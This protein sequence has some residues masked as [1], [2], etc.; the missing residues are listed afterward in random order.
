MNG[1]D[2]ADQLRSY[3]NTQRTT[4]KT[5]KPLWHFLFDVV[6]TNSYLLATH[7]PPGEPKRFPKGH[8]KFLRDLAE[9]LFKH[10]ER[11]VKP[12]NSWATIETNRKV[13]ET[14]PLRDLVQ[15]DPDQSQHI[16]VV[17]S[18]PKACV[19]CAA[20]NRRPAT[21]TQRKPLEEL[22]R[23]TLRGTAEVNKGR[24]CRVKRSRWGCQRCQINLCMKGPCW[25]E[26]IV[27]TN[28][29]PGQENIPVP[30]H[31]MGIDG[32]A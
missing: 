10:S 17:L 23:N 31:G 30:E 21:K 18:E 24:L 22:S 3:Y 5:W 7:P 16:Q 15:K 32:T 4:R 1:V 14:K 8:S 6:L 2:R 28:I 13:H 26:H 12:S 19:A 9:G 29:K 20:A 27:L 11:L 25:S